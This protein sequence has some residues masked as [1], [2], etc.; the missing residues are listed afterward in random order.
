[1][2]ATESDSSSSR[3]SSLGV[4]FHVVDHLRLPYLVSSIKREVKEEYVTPAV[5]RNRSVLA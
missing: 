5:R 4:T 1:M 3:S 2:S